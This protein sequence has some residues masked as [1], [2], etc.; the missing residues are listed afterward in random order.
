MNNL[1]REFSP[2]NTYALKT[3]CGAIHYI[4]TRY[5]QTE[6]GGREFDYLCG[7]LHLDKDIVYGVDVS[8]KGFVFFTKRLSLLYI[9]D[10]Y[11]HD[12]R[13]VEILHRT[14]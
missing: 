13:V 7:Y 4:L 14:T 5:R 10:D 12:N 2:I 9:H 11:S 1:R 6:I 3:I 8:A